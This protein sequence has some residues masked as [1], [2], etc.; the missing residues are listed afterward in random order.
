MHLLQ[1][2]PEKAG[3]GTRGIRAM[4]VSDMQYKLFGKT[5]LKVSEAALGTGTFGTAWGGGSSLEEAQQVF[6]DVSVA[7]DFDV[8]QIKQG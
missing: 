4:R 3:N 5:G 8:F 6:P 1:P 7:R 2:V